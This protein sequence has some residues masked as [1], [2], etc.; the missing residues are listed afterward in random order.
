MV[1]WTEHLPSV[2]KI[3]LTSD[4]TLNMTMTPHLPSLLKSARGALALFCVGVTTGLG[5]A[6]PLAPPPAPLTA[7]PLESPTSLAP[8]SRSETPSSVPTRE[9]L[10]RLTPSER[11]ARIQQLKEHRAVKLKEELTPAEREQRRQVIQQRL[12]QRLE[13]LHKKQKAGPLSP[14][15]EAS[16]KRLEELSKNFQRSKLQGGTSSPDKKRKN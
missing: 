6:E 2:M 16:L 11:E 14:E 12:Q 3:G 7:V 5:H 8:A 1:T 10:Q 9:D 15:E 4:R 13:V